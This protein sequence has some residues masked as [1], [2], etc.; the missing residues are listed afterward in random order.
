MGSYG[1]I[2]R[3]VAV[4]LTGK[5][6]TDAFVGVQV[7]GIRELLQKL[8]EFT[9]VLSSDEVMFNAVNEGAKIIEAD[10]KRRTQLHIATGNLARSVRV[11]EKRYDNK[12][13]GVAAVA[14][15]GPE[16][17]GASGASAGKGSGNHAWLVE[18]GSG[19][20]RPGTQGRRTY[21]NIHQKVNG[22]MGP[23]RKITRMDDEAFAKAGK[24]YYFLMGSL[25]ERA[26]QPVGRS[27]YSRDFA[28]GPGPRQHPITLKPGETIAPMPALGLMQ[29]SIANHRTNV[30]N[31]VVR[32]LKNAVSAYA[33]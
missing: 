3:F 15:V 33:A 16:F 1:A 25:R 26:N 9:S 31:A 12:D 20:R 2:P 30:Y 19:P 5:Q 10:Y 22:H 32:V 7:R 18:F 4:D 27:G 14:V 29:E 6:R 23:M 17:T 8:R 21:V 13:G 24:G 28:D 11:K